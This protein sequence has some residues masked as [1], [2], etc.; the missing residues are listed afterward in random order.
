M[1]DVAAKASLAKAEEAALLAAQA[2]VEEA[3][4]S[5]A[6]IELRL[7]EAQA[8]TAPER[9]QIARSAAHTAN[10]KETQLTHMHRGQ[11]VIVKVG[12]YPGK[13]FYGRVE[14]IAAATGARFSLLPPENA[15]GNFVKAVQ[16]IPVKSVL[17]KGNSYI[18][19][20]YRRLREEEV[21]VSKYQSREEARACLGRYIWECNHDQPHRGLGDR[22]P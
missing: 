16:R 17:D 20:L 5:L 9:V 8:E 4:Q 1:D 18:A 10:F 7:R 3:R 11:R 22:T 6:A 21:W 15:A 2:T 14:S 13:K 12:T 19:H